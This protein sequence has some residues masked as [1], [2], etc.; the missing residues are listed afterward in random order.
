MRIAVCLSGQPRT[1]KTASKNI[2]KYFE[3]KGATVDYF[4]HTWDTNTYR[5]LNDTS[6]RKQ[7]YKVSKEEA[8]EIRNTYNPLLMEFEEYDV[9]KFQRWTALFYSFMK[10]VW[11]KKKYEL[12]N[13]FEYDLVIK[14]RFDINFKQEGINAFHEPLNTFYLH[15][16]Y[17]LVAY[18]ANELLEHKFPTEYNQN[19]FD[20]VFFYSDS[21][22]MDVISKIYWW[23]KNIIK[24]SQLQASRSECITNQ[25]FFYGPGTLLYAYLIKYTIHPMAKLCIPYYV[26]RKEAEM[27]NLDGID[28]WEKML[29]ISHKFYWEVREKGILK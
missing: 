20:D 2:K 19:H 17:P 26:V 1:W 25:E 16:V 7:D 14:T 24:I 9:K 18:T 15:K 3:L 6:D 13:D 4:I 23:Y 5:D 11:L 28:D 27:L 12:E 8:V 29:D 22:T 10:S 21:R